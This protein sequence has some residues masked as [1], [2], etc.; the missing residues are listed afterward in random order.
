MNQITLIGRLTSD[1][2]ITATRGGTDVASLRL[3]VNDRKD[4]TLFIGVEAYGPQA[5]PIAEHLSKGRQVCV[6]GR[7]EID[8]WERDGV[9]RERAKVVASRVEFLG[10]PEGRRSADDIAADEAMAAAREVENDSDADIPF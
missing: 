1:P 2:E 7:L 9:K 5:K 3:A 4:V 6:V 10:A 8:S